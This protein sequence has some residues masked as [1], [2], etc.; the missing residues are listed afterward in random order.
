M[1]LTCVSGARCRDRHLR[2]AMQA[3]MMQGRIVAPGFIDMLAIRLSLDRQSS[4]ALS[5]ASHGNTAKRLHR[6]EMKRHR[7]QKPFLDTTN[8]D[9]LDH[10]D[11][12]FRRLKSRHTL[13]SALVGSARSR[14]RH[15]QQWADTL[16]SDQMKSLVEQP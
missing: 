16:Q 8:S 2:E 7:P 5:Q 1:P 10:L 4:S 12:Y 3:E 6:P 13:T 14:S 15:W 11:G 9:R